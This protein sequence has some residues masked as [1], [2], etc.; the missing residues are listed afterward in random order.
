M[1]FKSFCKDCDNNNRRIVKRLKLQHK[2]PVHGTMCNIR[3]CTNT[4]LCLDH[5]HIKGTF[6]GWI[7]AQHNAA[8]GVLGDNAEGVNDVLDYLVKRSYEDTSSHISYAEPG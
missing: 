4:K 1:L 2:K 7:C 6:R 3:K 8:I 5:D